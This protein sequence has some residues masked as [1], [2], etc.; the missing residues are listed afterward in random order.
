M[1]TA[2]SFLLTDFDY[3]AAPFCGFFGVFRQLAG[4]FV[5]LCC[6]QRVRTGEGHG[7]AAVAAFANGGDKLNGAEEWHVELLRGAFRTSA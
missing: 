2:V 7:Q 3:V 6:N 1:G 5:E 4:Y